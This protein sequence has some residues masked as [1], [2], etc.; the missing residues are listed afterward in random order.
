MVS[1]S[2]ATLGE[3]IILWFGKPA[4]TKR[5]VQIGNILLGVCHHVAQ[6]SLST[7]MGP[8][9]SCP[10]NDEGNSDY[11]YKA[12]PKDII[13]M[14]VGWTHTPECDTVI[15]QSST[16][17]YPYHFPSTVYYVVYVCDYLSFIAEKK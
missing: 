3:R 6:V 16:I 7:N 8:V 17:P 1:T 10:W 5:R 2:E 4:V 15:M 13:V 12:M 11:P 14:G 9:G